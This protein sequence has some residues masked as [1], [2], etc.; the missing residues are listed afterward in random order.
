MPH[1]AAPGK[2][3]VPALPDDFKV[4]RP[5]G[6]DAPDILAIVA[7]AVI[8]A[9]DKACLQGHISFPWRWHPVR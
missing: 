3:A 8:M 7:D 5:A 4:S 1:A 6:I 2:S 9:E